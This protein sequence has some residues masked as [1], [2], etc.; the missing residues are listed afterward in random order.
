MRKFST[1]ASRTRRMGALPFPI[2][3]SHFH[4]R[5]HSH[6]RGFVLPIVIIAT[7]LIAALAATTQAAVWRAARNARMGIAGERALH[8]ADAAIAN[9]IS[10][11]DPRAF[12]GI[13]VGGRV[14]STPTISHDLIANVTLV[15]T[16]LDGALIEAV[17]T[18]SNNGVLRTATRRVSRALTLRNPP[19][20]LTSPL[21]I[22]GAATFAAAGAVSNTDETPPGWANECAST[23]S[24]DAQ[25]SA[26]NFAA[27]QAQFD[28][29]WARWTNLASQIDDGSAV[30]SLAPFVTASLCAPGAGD[31]FRGAG[32]TAACTNEWG[33]RAVTLS[34]AAASAPFH[35]T[36]DS[37]H[38]G[39]LMIDG[40][41]VLSARLDVYGLLLVRGAVD[42]S[43]GQL[44]VHGAGLV[45]DNLSHGS[46][47][48]IAT[49]V[50]Y[51]RCALRRAWSATG[52]PA[53]VTSGGWLERF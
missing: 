40:D 5:S 53:A 42:A 41:L 23:D 13:A 3:H 43:A 4:S 37:R 1:T 47:F 45:R 50:R 8:G 49:R 22:L 30:T 27:Q 24:I 19:L 15:R 18:S 39:I 25:S 12:A 11:W 31:P 10:T 26:P 52:A 17:V 16:S 48:G 6:P 14:F 46:R 9:Q 36:R 38:Q 32:S 51:S 34:A 33:A 21:T 2:S 28:A 44:T 7:I 20:T 35:I 29:A